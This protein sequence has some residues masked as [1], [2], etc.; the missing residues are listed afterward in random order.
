MLN[1]VLRQIFVFTVHCFD[2]TLHVD[3]SVIWNRFCLWKRANYGNF[4][5]GSSQTFHKCT[6][7]YKMRFKVGREYSKYFITLDGICLQQKHRHKCTNDD[8]SHFAAVVLYA[9]RLHSLKQNLKRCITCCV[10]LYILHF[11][12]G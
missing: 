11:S 2:N 7:S 9:L 3:I 1:L 5:P 12:K 4:M 10:L 8:T 6:S